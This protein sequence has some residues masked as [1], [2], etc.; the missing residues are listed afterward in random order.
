VTDLRDRLRTLGLLA[1]SSAVDDIVALATKKRWGPT[2]LPEHL[3]D[4]EEKDR[5]RLS[6]RKHKSARFCVRLRLSGR[7][8]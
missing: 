8:R 1:A 3:G 6:H 4:I 7:V 2:E 5:A